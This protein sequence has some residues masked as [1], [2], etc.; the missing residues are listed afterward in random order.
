MVAVDPSPKVVP[1]ED[2]NQVSAGSRVIIPGKQEVADHDVAPSPAAVPRLPI[3]RRLDQPGRDHDGIL[4]LLAVTSGL[5]AL[6]A[7]LLR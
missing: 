7:T 6:V 4:Q 2:H 1:D 3:R 5:L